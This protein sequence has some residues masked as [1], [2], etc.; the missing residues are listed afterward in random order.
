M[1]IILNHVPTAGF[2]FALAFYLVALVLNN[3]GMKRGSLVLFVICSIVGVPTY[4]TGTAAMWALTQPPMPEISKAVINAHRDM[5]LLTLFGLAFTGAAAWI[6]H[7]VAQHL[8]SLAGLGDLDQA[9]DRAGKP[10]AFH[11]VELPIHLRAHL[12]SRVRRYA[13]ANV[14]GRVPGT[15][16]GKHAVAVTGGDQA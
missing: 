10:G 2:V 1:H 6:E 12:E 7:D 9:I 4:V 11:A 5:A 14:V 15:G 8:F 13:G 3:N 16:P